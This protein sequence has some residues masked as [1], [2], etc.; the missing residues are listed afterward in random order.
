MLRIVYFILRW[1]ESGNV[2]M[3]EFVINADIVT[4]A[5]NTPARE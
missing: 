5:T 1:V 2:N 4:L 3:Q